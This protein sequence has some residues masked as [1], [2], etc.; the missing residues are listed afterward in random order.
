MAH[1]KSISITVPMEVG[2]L[3]KAARLFNDMA[4][5][6][7]AKNPVDPAS[8]VTAAPITA[9]T[10]TEVTK[11]PAEVKTNVPP[12]QPPLP[13]AGPVDSDGVPWDERIHTKKKT[14]RKK[15][16]TWTPIKNLDKEFYAGVIA[17]L[18]AGAPTAPVTTPVDAVTTAPKP[19]VKT[20][21]EAVTY[22][23]LMQE[24]SARITAGE[25]S[26]EDVLTAIQNVAAITGKEIPTIPD[27]CNS[28]ALIP[29]VAKGIDAIWKRNTQS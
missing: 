3:Q 10:I 11:N 29:A 13:T 15:D 5:E 26:P 25:L 27:L 18:K 9:A 23:T 17:E 14:I 19:P 24:C 22:E 21:P 20:T 28:P 1:G 16:G 2:T 7:D 12:P 4:M 8:P 6:L